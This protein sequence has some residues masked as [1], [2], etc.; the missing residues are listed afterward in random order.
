MVPGFSVHDELEVLVRDA[1]FTRWEALVSATRNPAAFLGDSTG[2]VIRVGARADL[3]L[4]SANPLNDLAT[5]RAP[6]GVMAAGRW[7]DRTTLDAMLV[8]ARLR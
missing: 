6:A 3:I 1:G 7:L 2:G 8:E 5:L 4:V